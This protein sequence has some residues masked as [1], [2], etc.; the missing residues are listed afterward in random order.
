VWR[1]GLAGLEKAGSATGTPT[2]D[3]LSIAEDVA[4]VR[5][6]LDG[7]SGPKILVGHSYGGIV[8]S[9][10]AYGRSD[11]LGL[12]FTAAFVPDQ[13]DSIF[14]LG[15]GLHASEAFNHFIWTGTPF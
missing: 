9:N 3:L 8:I 11:V 7:I 14:S 2:L 6:V 15:A 4:I 5:A 1:T 13:G 12:V 10:A